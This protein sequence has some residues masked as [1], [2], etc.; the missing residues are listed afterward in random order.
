ML[1]LQVVE[2]AQPFGGQVFADDRHPEVA[3]VLAAVSFGQREAPEAGGVG[4]TYAFGEEGFP[5][6]VRKATVG[7]VGTG[8]FAPV[9]EEAVVVV[10]VLEGGYG[11][12]GKGVKRVKVLDEVRGKVEIHF[13]RGRSN[14]RAVG[15]CRLWWRVGGL[16]VSEGSPLHSSSTAFR[17]F[18]Q[19]YTIRSQFKMR[20]VSYHDVCGA[21]FKV[22]LGYRRNIKRRVPAAHSKCSVMISSNL[23][24][25]RGTFGRTDFKPDS[26]SMIDLHRNCIR[27][28]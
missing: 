17:C 6:W 14:V 5:V 9:V 3:A 22:H 18:S 8:V 13:E 15:S 19:D 21:V 11:G 25:V 28:C 12:V 27:S 2:Q 1:V 4:A 24:Q 23:V 20:K 16:L 26:M 10:R 7:P